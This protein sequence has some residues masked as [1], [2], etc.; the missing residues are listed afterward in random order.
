MNDEVESS[1][2]GERQWTSARR[3]EKEFV[4]I[5]RAIKQIADEHGIATGPVI[6]CLTQK[7]LRS[8]LELVASQTGKE[9]QAEYKRRRK[10]PDD[11]LI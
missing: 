8:T 11:G 3:I 7:G 4:E 2:D 6:N 1:F 9:M 5:A 10:A